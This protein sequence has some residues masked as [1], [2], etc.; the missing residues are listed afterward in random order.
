MENQEQPKPEP[1]NIEQ[2]IVPITYQGIPGIT[3][4][5][6]DPATKER[7]I[8][9]VV[10]E[11]MLDV[12]WKQ[13]DRYCEA[14]DPKVEKRRIK[15]KRYSYNFIKESDVHRMAQAFNKVIR[16]PI[17][18]I[19]R[20]DENEKIFSKTD[21]G[22]MVEGE[23]NHRGAAVFSEYK[24]MIADYKSKNEAL[25]EEVKTLL[26]KNFATSSR[27][28]NWQI[29]AII[30]LVI[31]VIGGVGGYLGYLQYHK[32]DTDNDKV[33]AEN[34]N[35]QKENISLKTMVKDLQ[36]QYQSVIK[37]LTPSVQNEEI[38]AVKKD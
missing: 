8:Q 28:K 15:T 31:L 30:S 6:T 36:D 26:N 25:N 23:V 13:F 5:Y 12:R 24:N 29:T 16:I 34:E 37:K 11:H 7:W 19:P 27:L 4:E 20:T 3:F 33:L 10:G 17:K 1:Q 35:I 38:N 9:Q 2:D 18:D 32:L 14:I 22:S 21:V